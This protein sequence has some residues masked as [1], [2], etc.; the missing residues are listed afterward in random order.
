MTDTT[1]WVVLNHGGRDPFVDYSEGPGY[2]EQGVHPPVNFHAFAAA[3]NGAFFDSVDMVLA[4]DRLSGSKCLVLLRSKLQPALDAVTALKKADRTVFVSWKEC[5]QA[6]IANQLTAARSLTIYQ[7]ILAKCDGVLSPTLAEP[8]HVDALPVYMIPTPYPLDFS[9]WNYEAP[10]EQRQG[11]FIGTREFFTPTRNHLSA[12]TAALRVAKEVDSFVTVIN[13]D[14]GKG[15]KLLD[16]LDN[17]HLRII[18]G[19]LSYRDYLKR[20]ASHR[21]VFQLDRSSVPGQ[22][23]GDALLAR[24]PCIGGNSAI[25]QLAFPGESY[26]ALSETAAEAHLKELLTNDDDLKKSIAAS[27]STAAEKVSFAAVISQLPA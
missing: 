7:K 9:E 6:Q 16:T 2:F 14:K 24:V 10:F 27:Q 18:D 22:V 23:A 17:G 3:T 4:D 11:I 13:T 12:L 26:P 25:E 5:G 19:S 1:P 8:P 20:I 15:R 21:V